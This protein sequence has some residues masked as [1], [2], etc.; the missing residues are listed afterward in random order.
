MLI[1][2]QGSMCLLDTVDE[3]DADHIV[4]TTRQHA[5]ATNPLRTDG[6][7]SCVH[8]IE[9]AAQ[10]MAVHGGL[11][12]PATTAPRIG[13]LLSVRQCVFNCARLDDI[14]APLRI[15]A[16]RIAGSEAALSYRFAV[17]AADVLLLEGRAN[18]MLQKEKNR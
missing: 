4:C 9:F 3:W 10:A 16:N 7:L 14:D 6:A 18:V 12:A 11:M 17:H 5:I 15:E 2:H 8:G 13:L 1:P